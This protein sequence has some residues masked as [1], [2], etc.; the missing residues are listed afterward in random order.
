MKIIIAET[1]GF[2]F[3]VRRVVDLAIDT[4]SGGQHQIQTLGPVI[5]NAQ[6]V[7]MLRERG[8]RVITTPAEIENGATVLI[9][10]HGIAPDTE[11]EVTGRARHVLDGTCPK[12]KTVHRVI[13]K[14][15]ADGY[16]IIIAG[17][18]G[19]AEVVAL[20]GYA[21]DSGHLVC[22]PDQIGQLPDFDNVCLVSQTTF[23]RSVFDQIAAAVR[24]RYAGKN[25]IIKKTICG[26]TNKRQ[27]ETR[28]LAERADAMIVVGGK[29]SAN[30]LR[31]AAIAAETGKPVQHVETE[32][33]IDELILDQC[34][35]LGI[36]AGASTPNWMIRRVADYA[37]YLSRRRQKNPLM[38]LHSLLETLTSLNI[39]LAGGAAVM[40]AVACLLQGQ[41][42]KLSGMAMS[43]LYFF[44]L[45]LWNSLAS[46]ELTQHHGIGRYRTYHTFKRM[47]YILATAG[48]LVMLLVAHAASPSV[49]WVLLFSALAGTAYHLTIV[50]RFLQRF[51]RYSNLKDVPTSRDLFVALAWGT[52][53]TF[54]ASDGRFVVAMPT[55]FC[56]GWIFVLA[57]LRSV[58]FDLRD[59]EGDRIM[60]R[61]TLVTY[62]GE[63]RIRKA[64]LALLPISLLGLVIYPAV[65]L[66]GQQGISNR[67]FVFVG[68]IPVLVYI[69]FFLKLNQRISFRR[70]LFFTILADGQFY[71]SGLLGLCVWVLTGIF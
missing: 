40:Y 25:V 39:F 43:F 54:L 1:A 62:V 24:E 51:V 61:E 42:V 9:R 15:R 21:G 50:P 60:G 57:Y 19:H 33:E 70:N 32:N 30:T 2:C 38:R 64:I 11:R 12:V 4:T 26:A 22:S 58:I 34:E 20:Q 3:G 8:A 63:K 31:L 67:G 59:I 41:P 6:T 71:L 7:A 13:H 56:F 53:L 17:D 16:A 14:Y 68:Q 37:L 5:H 44:S 65:L 36:T 18:K 47:L 66:M 45:Y 29:H 23:D 10:A 69:Y 35:T 49:F 52:I 28:A 27:D 48:I 46:I 55:L